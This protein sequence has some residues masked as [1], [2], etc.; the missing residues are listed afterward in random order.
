MGPLPPVP[1]LDHAAWFYLSFAGNILLFAIILW[2]IY[3]KCKKRIL[4]FVQARQ[5]SRQAR[6]RNPQAN[7]DSATSAAADAVNTL[8]R[9]RQGYFSISEDSNE[10]DP[11][12]P[13]AG[14]SGFTNVPLNFPPPGPS[15]KVPSFLNTPTSPLRFS[16]LD[17][18]LKMK[19]FKSRDIATQTFDDIGETRV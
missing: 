13:D 15:P 18:F 2:V 1:P 17:E 4:R 8:R 16:N 3:L 10:S 5:A 7:S 9:Q 19:T 14:P 12:I 6:Q 11:L